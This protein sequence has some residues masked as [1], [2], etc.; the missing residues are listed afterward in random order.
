MKPGQDLKPVSYFKNNMAEVI[1][2]V[3]LPAASRGELH[4]LA[5]VTPLF[6]NIF[7]NRFFIF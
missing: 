3:K 7:E 4:L 6:C 5:E 1:G 2:K